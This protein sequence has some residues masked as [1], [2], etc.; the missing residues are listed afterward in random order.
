MKNNKFV[1]FFRICFHCLSVESAYSGTAN[2]I[3]CKKAKT[4]QEMKFYI[5]RCGNCKLNES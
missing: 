3:D 2:F 1:L 4:P 5:S